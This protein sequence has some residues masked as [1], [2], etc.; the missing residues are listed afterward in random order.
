[1]SLWTSK[2]LAIFNVKAN[3]FRIFK[4]II[5]CDRTQ[6]KFLESQKEIHQKCFCGTKEP[7]NNLDNPLLK[8]ISVKHLGFR[9]DVKQLEIKDIQVTVTGRRNLVPHAEKLTGIPI[10]TLI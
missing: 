3:G 1:M 6:N 10:A 9:R 7:Q 4:A 8:L 5:R 2:L